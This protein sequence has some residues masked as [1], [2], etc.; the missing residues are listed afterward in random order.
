MNLYDYKKGD[1]V[2]ILNEQYYACS[3][4]IIDII[5]CSC[6]IK[7][8][9]VEL[10]C[11]SPDYTRVHGKDLVP[12]IESEGTFIPAKI[13]DNS[14]IVDPIAA[15]PELTMIKAYL[16]EDDRM[17]LATEIFKRKI[18]ENFEEI[19]KNRTEAN[20]SFVDQVVQEVCDVYAKKLAPEY[21]DKFMDNIK[22]VLSEEPKNND[23][24]PGD[25]LTW[26]RWKV[27]HVAEEWINSNKSAIISFMMDTIKET[28]QNISVDKLNKVITKNVSET[29]DNILSGDGDI[30][31]TEETE[32]SEA[33]IFN[34]D[35]Y[36]FK[37]AITCNRQHVRLGPGTNYGRIYAIN[38]KK[39]D[40]VE[41]KEVRN[42]EEGSDMWGQI[43]FTKTVTENGKK[44]QKYDL[45]WIAIHSKYNHVANGIF[46]VTY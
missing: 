41:I 16:S 12:A 20:R 11:T 24:D 42:G 6:G 5:D 1:N 27:E 28:S 8:Y 37:V 30:E 43:S 29:I 4:T 44:V 22:K 40:E 38:L 10:T 9:D 45:G 46:K 39:G 25:F 19:M 3:G 7:D 34:N 35:S 14:S 31:Y 2:I 17:N 18:S 21:E 33:K 13:T 26:L 15:N 36:L 23:E 32:D